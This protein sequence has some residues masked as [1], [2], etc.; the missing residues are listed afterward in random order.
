MMIYRCKQIRRCIHTDIGVGE[1]TGEKLGLNGF[2]TDDKQYVL[3][4]TASVV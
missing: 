4:G 3:T 1:E 2:I